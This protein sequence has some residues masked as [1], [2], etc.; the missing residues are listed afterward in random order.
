MLNRMKKKSRKRMTQLVI[1]LITTVVGEQPLAKLVD[2]LITINLDTFR[3]II[4]HQQP[5]SLLHYKH[6]IALSD[7]SAHSLSQLTW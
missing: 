2:F 4:T 7:L 5:S 6:P 3:G 1:Q